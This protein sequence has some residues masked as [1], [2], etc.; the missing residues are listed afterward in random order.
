LKK[1]TDINS[2]AQTVV[3]LADKDACSITGQNIFV[4]SGT[5]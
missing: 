3:F 5:I 4:D 1:A 2:V